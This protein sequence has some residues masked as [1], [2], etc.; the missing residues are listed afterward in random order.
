MSDWAHKQMSTQKAV[1]LKK[2]FLEKHILET[3]SLT[4]GGL[5]M[6]NIKE[7]SELGS[8][9]D[10]CFIPVQIVFSSDFGELAH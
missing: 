6:E 10:L 8:L 5:G 7:I 2:I 4:P 9:F 3:Q 1:F